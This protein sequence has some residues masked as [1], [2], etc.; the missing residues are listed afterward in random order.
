MASLPAP[1]F[2]G[3]VKALKEKRLA[4][5]YLLHG[6]EGYF[7]DALAS[8]FEKVLGEDEQVFNQYV[9]YAPDTEA[10]RVCELCR[11]VPMMSDRLMVILRE[12]QAVN[13]SYLD[14]LK[15]YVANPSPT[16]T[17]VICF[18]GAKAKGKELM[19]ALKKCNAVVFESKKLQD[20]N[21]A[22]YIERYIKSKGLGAEQKAVEMLRDYVGTDLSR[23]YNEIDKLSTLLPS[24]GAVTP[25]LVERHIGVS[26]EYNTFELVDAFAARD[27]NRVFRILTYFRSNPKAVPLVVASSL[28]FNFFADLL[29]AY[30]VPGGS[31][32]AISQELKLTNSFALKRIR[33][34]M[35]R[36]NA[37]QIIEILG[38]I[39][40]FDTAAKGV[41]SRQNE[42][43]LFL[44][45][46]YH[47]LSA[48]GRL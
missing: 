39:R 24:G 7:I 5:V 20:Y 35:S 15:N 2:E 6:E 21:I 29:Q 1:T 40:R 17:L 33:L 8:E 12:A 28:I 38:A 47:I 11:G 36:Y 27:P 32:A 4:P 16:T 34:G 44:D 13:A 18:R 30:Y 42:H 10:S 37:F 31:D 14:K 3:I 48:P 22:P 41:E 19:A 25:E 9:V 43:Q 45:L 23:L 46:A 26:K